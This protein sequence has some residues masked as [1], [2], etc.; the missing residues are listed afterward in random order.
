M[1][2]A[3]LDQAALAVDQFQ[4]YQ[5]GHELHMTQVAQRP[6]HLVYVTGVV[7]QN[8]AVPVE[9]V[10]GYRVVGCRSEMFAGTP[11]V[12]DFGF[13]RQRLEEGPIVGGA[14]GDSDD[15]SVGAQLPDMCDFAC[16]SRF[17][18]DRAA[19]WHAVEIQGLQT[20]ARG[21]VEGNRTAGGLALGGLGR[22]ALAGE[23][24]HHD[25]AERHRGAV[26]ASRRTPS[27]SRMLCSVSGPR[28]LPVLVIGSC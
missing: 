9:P 8:L 19:L 10:G 22:A 13:G 1:L 2:N 27:A 6:D 17:Q 3:S 15:S 21:V 20:L 5:S 23:Q 7:T 4:L 18:C 12:D 28:G 16:E 11:E 25:A 26:I 14:V 24:R